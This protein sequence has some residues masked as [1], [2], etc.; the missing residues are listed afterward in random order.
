[1]TRIDFGRYAAADARKKAALAEIKRLADEAAPHHDAVQEADRILED[2]HKL[3]G[4]LEKAASVAK[5]GTV[6]TYA[7]DRAVDGHSLS[8]YSIGGGCAETIGEGWKTRSRVKV[9]GD[10]W[11]FVSGGWAFVSGGGK[12]RRVTLE[13]LEA[14]L[15]QLGGT[16]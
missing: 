4:K 11:A 12:L 3:R 6:A 10:G 5:G 1:M 7:S 16:S 9:D 14:A 2:R 15:S 13:E 8:L